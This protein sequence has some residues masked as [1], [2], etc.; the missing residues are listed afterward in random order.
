MRPNIYKRIH[1]EI[2]LG[3]Y[4]TVGI[5]NYV[6]HEMKKAGLIGLAKGGQQVFFA[7][8][9][10]TQVASLDIVKASMAAQS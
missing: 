4:V 3:N 2:E 7:S 6:I 10:P 8:V 9:E 1:S 5:F